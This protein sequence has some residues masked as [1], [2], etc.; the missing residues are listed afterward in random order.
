MA[1]GKHIGKVVVQ[2][3]PEEAGTVIPRPVSVRAEAR[4]CCDQHASYLITGGLGGFGLEL[5]QWLVG[6][7]AR[8]L[9]SYDN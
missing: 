2:M 5:A 8:K 9:A 7:G 6:R 1:S 4:T 3:R